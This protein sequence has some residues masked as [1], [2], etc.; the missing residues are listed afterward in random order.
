MFVSER[1]LLRPADGRSDAATPETVF[2]PL[3]FLLTFDDG[4]HAN[5]ATILGYL[6]DNSVQPGVKAVFFVQT[7][8]AQ[9]GGCREGRALLYRTHVAGHV[10]GLHTGTT[11]G[12]VSHTGMAS[13]ELDRSLCDGK[14][15]LDALT[16]SKPALVRPPYWW[17]NAGTLEQ[18]ER[19]DLSMMLSDI[20]AYDGVNWGMHVFKRWSF[21]SQLRRTRDRVLEDRL[22]VVNGAIPIVVTFHDTNTY[23]ARHM[24]D[25][26]RLLMEETRRAELPLHEKP[27]YDDGA[28]VME[29]GLRRAV[30]RTLSASTGKACLAAR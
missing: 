12:H 23:T 27:F 15:D 14:K 17:F 20:K 4:P 3:R 25:Y 6:S 28:D 9:G 10:L 7:R 22:P 8:N 21:R 13:A 2:P 16:G 30:R 5:T 19:H 24:D 1:E 18:Y 11:R 29:V 26:L